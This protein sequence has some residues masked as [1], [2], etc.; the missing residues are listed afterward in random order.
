MRY[1]KDLHDAGY[2]HRDLKPDNVLLE[3]I[4]NLKADKLILIDF[5]LAQ[6]YLDENNEHIGDDLVKLFVGNHIFASRR[7]LNLE[8]KVMK[9]F[10]KLFVLG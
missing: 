5:G 2:L 3:D 7:A 9:G 10:T 6:P 4:D 1:L 8:S